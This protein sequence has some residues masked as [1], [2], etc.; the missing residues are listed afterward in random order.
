MERTPVDVSTGASVRK[1]GKAGLDLTT[2]ATVS[3]LLREG[4]EDDAVRIREF[5]CGLS[6]TSQ[7]LRFF[8]SVAPPSSGLLRVLCGGTGADILLVTD[9]SGAVIAHGMAAD[10]AVPGGQASNIGLVVADSW[11]QRG[12]GTLLLSTLVGRAARRGVTSLVLDVLPS[13]DRMLGIIARRWPDA[14]RERT[15][16]A[17]VIRPA[18]TRWQATGRHTVP[19]VVSIRRDPKTRQSGDPR[20]SDRT[21]A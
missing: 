11:Q 8:A 17:I 14:P 9:E 10:T 18:I 16:D 7:Y 13:N 12:L 2:S 20:A 4:S 21:A 15:R 3:G 5:V 19:D 6:P 1:P